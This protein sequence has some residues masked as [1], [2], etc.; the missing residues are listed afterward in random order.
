MPNLVAQAWFKVELVGYP[1][2][3][4]RGSGPP[5]V[6]FKNARRVVVK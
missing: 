4:G 3:I 1:S 2:A 6:H 5:V